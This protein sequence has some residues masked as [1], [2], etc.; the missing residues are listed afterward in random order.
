MRLLRHRIRQLKGLMHTITGRPAL[1]DIPINL[2]DTP[3]HLKP[4]QVN[5]NVLS[6]KPNTE[7]L[8]LAA[9]QPTYEYGYGRPAQTY[10]TTKTYY[11]QASASYVA[12]PSYVD[13]NAAKTYAQ[14]PTR[15]PM[16]KVTQYS[17]P[18]ASKLIK[19]CYISIRLIIELS[20]SGSGKQAAS[21]ECSSSCLF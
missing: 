9:P 11:Q 4:I 16:P 2:Q 17:A 18:S 7:K 12:A 10:D 20:F 13:S 6:L 3:Q 5:S 8:I 19:K 14:P 15:A 1:P 21:S